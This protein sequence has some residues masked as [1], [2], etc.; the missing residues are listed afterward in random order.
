MRLS[1]SISDGPG[2]YFKGRG[3]RAITYHPKVDQLTAYSKKILDSSIRGW[4]K[5]T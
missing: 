1:D 4:R 5:R 3:P 2:S